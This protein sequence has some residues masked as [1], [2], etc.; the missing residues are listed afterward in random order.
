MRM[1]RNHFLFNTKPARRNQD[2]PRELAYYRDRNDTIW[3]YCLCFTMMNIHSASPNI[4]S[5]T[6]NI[7]SPILNINLSACG[8]QFK[9]ACL[10]FFM[11][12]PF[13]QRV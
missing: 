6:G 7:R 13:N 11:V 5:P 3:R 10:M 8:Q 12:F 1:G 9:S 4:R 2:A